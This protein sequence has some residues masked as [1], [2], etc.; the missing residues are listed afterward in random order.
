MNN[1]PLPVIRGL[2]L[3]ILTVQAIM[4]TAL[5]LNQY[6]AISIPPFTQNI[7]LG[8]VVLWS[9]AEHWLEVTE[10]KSS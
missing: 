6:P 8:I 2:R 9:K 4:M 3:A 10:R 1:P 7:V 5:T